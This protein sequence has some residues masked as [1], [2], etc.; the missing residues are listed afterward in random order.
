M[1]M[2]RKLARL[3]GD[4]RGSY[5]LEFAMIAP[6]FLVILL[7][8]VDIGLLLFVQVVL[9]G[10]ARDAA[11][12]IRT[13]QI[14]GTGGAAQT[15]FETVLCS[16]VHGLV[17][18]CANIT[19]YVDIMTQ[20]SDVSALPAYQSP[21]SGQQTNPNGANFNPGGFNGQAKTF[22]TGSGGSLVVVRIAYLRKSLVPF[23]NPIAILGGNSM[24]LA[25]LTSTALTSTVVFRNEP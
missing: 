12:E 11:R 17:T 7:E 16:N 19:Y 3:L 8:T 22:N 10:A 15:N 23:A 5:A 1:G 6:F 14:V 4:E 24:N 21:T 18:S 25:S 13:G 9:D 2:V 20:F